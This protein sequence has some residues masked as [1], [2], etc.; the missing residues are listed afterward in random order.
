MS[1]PS[2]KPARRR[3]HTG[4]LAAL[5]AT[6]L[7]AG[8]ASSPATSPR[9]AAVDTPAMD[10]AAATLSDASQTPENNDQAR[11]MAALGV[12][13]D[14]DPQADTRR[15]ASDF[16]DLNDDGQRD[17]VAFVFG[18]QGCVHGCDLFVFQRVGDR[19]DVLNRIPTARPPLYALAER[20]TGWRDLAMRTIDAD[21]QADHRQRLRFMAGAY[22]PVAGESVSASGR[23]LIGPA[24]LG[25]SRSLSAAAPTGG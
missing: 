19:F 13:Y 14:D 2:D 17:A 9:T 23:T 18:A 4:V 12:I 11:L 22:T 24:D 6:G 7:L 8:C 3:W 21:G 15:V 5:A 25:S 1:W 16:I 20:H 10:R